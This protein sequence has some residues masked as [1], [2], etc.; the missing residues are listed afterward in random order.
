MFTRFPF[1]WKNPSG[2]FVAAIL[3]F[4]FAQLALTYFANMVSLEIGMDF[5]ITSLTEDAKRHLCTMNDSIKSG[6]ADRVNIHLQISEYIRLHSDA[7]R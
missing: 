2:F 1:D 5:F 7:K 3:T 4:A 6:T